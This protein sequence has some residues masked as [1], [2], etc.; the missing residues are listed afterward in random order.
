MGGSCGELCG[1]AV[2]GGELWGGAVQV[3]HFECHFMR[4]PQ[5][6]QCVHMYS[7]CTCTV[8]LG[9][10]LF[11]QSLFDSVLI[12]DFNNIATCLG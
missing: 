6:V 1:K 12:M 2:A 5:E 3:K 8:C 4:P 7:V 9:L 11:Y 10:S